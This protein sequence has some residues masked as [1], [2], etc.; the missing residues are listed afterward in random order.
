MRLI[1]PIIL[2]AGVSSAHAQE[3]SLANPESITCGQKHCFVSNI[4]EK[5]D[6]TA[7]DG[8][9]FIVRTDL[10][11]RLVAGSTIPEES[12]LN[13]PKG[14]A[15]LDDVLY[16]VDLDRVV[17]F[18][19]ESGEAQGE[20]PALDGTEGLNDIAVLG[21][22][23]LV[24][25]FTGGRLLRL[26]PA[27]GY[28]VLAEGIPGANGVIAAPDNRTAYVAAS[29]AALNGGFLYQVDLSAGAVKPLSQETGIFDGITWGPSGKLIVTDW[30][31]I[32]APTS[33]RILAFDPSSGAA[34]EI[35]TPGPVIGPADLTMANQKLLIPAL[36]E[37]RIVSISIK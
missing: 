25:D 3:P 36:P 32:H 37:G 11:G 27:E 15:L 18:D 24:T 35:D 31:D 9:G 10:M 8:D 33:G 22:A 5:F 29:G 26:D 17:A 1:L 2:A 7:K 30:V 4:G 21:D 20:W 28:S 16:A 6:A 12:V 34:R 14:L 13:A 19:A 23:L